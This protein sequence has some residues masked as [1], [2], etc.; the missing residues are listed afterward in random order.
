MVDL[1]MTLSE[2]GSKVPNTGA[3]TSANYAF[4]YHHSKILVLVSIGQI[5]LSKIIYV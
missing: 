2:F 4:H 5:N 3:L 1:D